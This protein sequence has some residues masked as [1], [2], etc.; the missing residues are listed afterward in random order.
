MSKFNEGDIVWTM[1]PNI[2]AE[3]YNYDGPPRKPWCG[4]V[5]KVSKG[6]ESSSKYS[7]KYT[8]SCIDEQGI[9]DDDANATAWC[10]DDE[11]Y[12]TKEQ[13]YEVYRENLR[14]RIADLEYEQAEITKELEKLNEQYFTS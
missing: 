6:V 2:E 13:A 12:A 14:E 5:T 7:R 8:V 1:R 9:P 3:S 4:K 10:G 11:V